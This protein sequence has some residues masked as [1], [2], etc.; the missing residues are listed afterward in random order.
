MSIAQRPDFPFSAVVGQSSLKT[1]LILNAINPRVGGLLISGPRGTAKSTLARGLA[2]ILPSADNGARAPFVNLPLGTSED[3]LTG[4]LDLQQALRDK[5]LAFQPGLLARAHDGV[6]YVDEVNLLPDALV[7]LLLD[8]AARGVNVVERDGISHSHA[9]HF[10]LVGTMNPDE[11]DLRPQLL[12]RFGLSI[13]LEAPATV[14]DRVAVV[15]QREAYER[16]PH[17]FARQYEAQQR[18]LRSRITQAR[19]RLPAVEADDACYHQIAERC[20]QAG[21]EG[22]RADVI[23]LQAAQAYAAWEDRARVSQAD[24]DAV[25]PWVLA[26]RQQNPEERPPEGTPPPSGGGDNRGESSGPGQPSGSAFNSK[27]ANS[28]GSKSADSASAQGGEWG[29]MPPQPQASVRVAAPDAPKAPEVRPPSPTRTAMDT[30]GRK[31]G[32]EGPGPHQGKSLSKRPDWFAT[33]VASRGQWPPLELRFRRQRTS[34]PW[35]HLV[36]MDTSGSTLGG[37]L[38]GQAKGLVEQLSLRA[39][40]AREHIAVLGFGNNQVQ[41]LLP[42]QRAPKTLTATLNTWTGGGGTPLRQALQQAAERIRL[43]RRREPGLHIRTWII[44]DGRTRE[45]LTGLPGLGDCVVVDIEPTFVKR[46]RTRELAASLAAAL[47]AL[48]APEAAR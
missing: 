47:I 23:W 7:D 48:P 26:H 24:L 15:R 35:L 13:H 8:T 40:R 31:R 4:T 12:D 6:L 37:T 5:A 18:D 44:T 21:V 42:R 33:L 22:L 45:P 28:T 38:L 9:A 1:A 29:A 39:Y 2:D 17:A 46:G 3:R 43:W 10:L 41:E 32:H 27:G 16:D 20:L 25:A 34:Q 19:E 30:A 36:L 14:A 11:G